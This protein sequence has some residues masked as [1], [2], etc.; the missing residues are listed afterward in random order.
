M[1]INENKLCVY[2]G[3]GLLVW[4]EE[5][6][7]Q[8]ICP[9]WQLLLVTSFKCQSRHS[10]FPMR[11]KLKLEMLIGWSKFS[12]NS[13]MPCVVDAGFVLGGVICYQ[14][15]HSTSLA[16]PLPSYL[17]LLQYKPHGCSQIFKP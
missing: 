2:L 5:C 14:V 12:L 4:H 7:L 15:S 16:S 3:T 9:L 13:Q 1:C 11:G 17:W 6:Q 8:G 10:C